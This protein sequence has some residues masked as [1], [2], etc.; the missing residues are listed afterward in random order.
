MSGPRS[1]LELNSVPIYSRSTILGRLPNI[2]YAIWSMF[3]KSHL[4]Y[5]SN[6]TATAV[7]ESTPSW[8]EYECQTCRRHRNQH[9][10]LSCSTRSPQNWSFFRSRTPEKGEWANY[11][12]AI[13]KP[14]LIHPLLCLFSSYYLDSAYQSIVAS[15]IAK[16]ISQSESSNHH[17]PII[18]ICTSCSYPGTWAKPDM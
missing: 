9:D 5:V 6:M 12:S 10:M 15:A 18:R 8:G 17:T 2:P 16:P 7:D 14:F 13:H 4:I 11:G 3:P 1:H